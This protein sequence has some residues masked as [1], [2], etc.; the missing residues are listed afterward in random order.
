MEEES[1]RKWR[2]EGYVEVSDLSP[3]CASELPE[4][5]V[6]GAQAWRSAW[7]A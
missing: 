5:W 2:E 6:A 3:H 1:A 7:A 4:R